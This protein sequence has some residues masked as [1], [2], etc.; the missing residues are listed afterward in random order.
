MSALLVR[1]TET[2]DPDSYEVIIDVRAV[3]YAKVRTAR[4]VDLY[5][6]DSL[7]TL[8]CQRKILDP[9]ERM[10]GLGACPG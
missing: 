1:F 2:P 6:L 7:K 9:S 3:S 10:A 5:L 4:L 8:R